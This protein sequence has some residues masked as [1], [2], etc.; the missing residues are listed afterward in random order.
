MI[1]KKDN[2]SMTVGLWN[3]FPDEILKPIIYLDRDY[4]EI[5]F[6]NCS[7]RLDGNKV[8]LSEIAQ[9]GFAGFEVR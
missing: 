2:N 4:S 7:G 8:F 6:I 9:Y 5:S 1:A 3:I